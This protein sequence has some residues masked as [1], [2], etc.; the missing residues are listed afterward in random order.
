ML[1]IRKD[2]VCGVKVKSDEFVFPY[3]GK[4]YYFDSAACRD[5]FIQNPEKFIEHKKGG[6]FKWL[7]KG[8]KDVP[9]SCHECSPQKE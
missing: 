4:T 1:R 9:K 6:F 2:P 3:Q 7:A 8:S 5:T